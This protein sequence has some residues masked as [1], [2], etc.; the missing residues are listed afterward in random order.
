MTPGPIP[1]PPTDVGPTPPQEICLGD[2]ITCALII[3][4]G[5]GNVKCWGEC[6]HSSSLSFP[7]LFS[8]EVDSVS[9]YAQLWR[10]RLCQHLQQHRRRTRRDAA[11]R[12]PYDLER[13][14]ARF[15][16]CC[17]QRHDVAILTCPSLQPWVASTSPTSLVED[18]QSVLSPPPERCTVGVGWRS[19]SLVKTMTDV[20]R[21]RIQ[22]LWSSRS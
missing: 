18:I 22:R 16:P 15:T 9:G 7:P 14:R 17:L 8:S 2:D 13:E 19:R 1:P 6:L 4:S 12:C 21:L 10:S 3:T 5:L 11:S 20:W